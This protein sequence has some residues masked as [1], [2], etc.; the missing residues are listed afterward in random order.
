MIE[1]QY[2]NR[3]TEAEFDGEIPNAEFVQCKRR[4]D[5]LVEQASR[6]IKSNHINGGKF[7]YIEGLDT[8]SLSLPY[9]L[10]GLKSKKLRRLI[11]TASKQE[12]LNDAGR[13]YLSAIEELS[14]I[15]I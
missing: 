12:T 1:N 6:N 13:A 5:R 7:R 11:D 9:N 10:H 3:L 14:L 4:L 8:L 15:H 2:T